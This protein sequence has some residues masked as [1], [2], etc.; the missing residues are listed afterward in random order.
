MP[1]NIRFYKM[2]GTSITT[3]SDMSFAIRL[4]TALVQSLARQKPKQN[5]LTSFLTGQVLDKKGEQGSFFNIPLI[6]FTPATYIQR[7]LN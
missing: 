6:C 2:V 7:Q 1:Y 3:H 4:K 5:L